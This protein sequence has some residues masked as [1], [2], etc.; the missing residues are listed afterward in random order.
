M[1][2][3][4]VL[5][6][7]SVPFVGGAE[8]TQ[9]NV[10]QECVRRGCSVRAVVPDAGE[11]ADRLD[12]L[13]ATVTVGRE[14]R[15]SVDA[16]RYRT[17]TRSWTGAVAMGLPSSPLVGEVFRLR[18][19]VIYCGGLRAQARTS[20]AAR[21]ARRPLAWHV[22]EHYTGAPARAMRVLARL[23]DL[24]LTVSNSVAEQAALRTARRVR[25]VLNGVPDAFFDTPAPPR[26]SDAI[27]L[28]S[29]GH[30]TPL[31]G[32]HMYFRLVEA[33]RSAGEN[34][35]AVLL[36][37]SPYLTS[38]HDGYA[39][40]V[41]QQA[42]AL[43]IDCRSVPPEGVPHELSRLDVLVHVADRP[44][45][46]GRALAEA[47]AS[48]IPVVTFAW[49]G[50]REI[51]LDGHTGFLVPPRNLDAAVQAT[52]RL[53]REPE[54]REEMGRNARRHATVALREAR[55]ADQGASALLSLC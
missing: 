52:L 9:L 22:H 39:D 18:E 13:N 7:S 47:Q 48:G 49:G 8:L 46:F 25:S 14:L 24:V 32:H 37:G 41:R 12:G 29:V 1:A 21:V 45:G 34:V 38:S 54:L 11:L 36:G 2:K 3:E 17:G 6:V 40:R 10:L 16:S 44:E 5:Y 20:L 50:A 43:R 26:R 42:S 31:K 55:A 30:L 51:V 53:V 15:A 35:E 27:G 19:G 23:P 4:T 33:V 28:G